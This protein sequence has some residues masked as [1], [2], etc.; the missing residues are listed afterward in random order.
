MTFSLATAK[1]LFKLDNLYKKIFRLTLRLIKKPYR[2]L[3]SSNIS[4]SNNS[5][6]KRSFLYIS[7]TPKGS[8]TLEAAIA[9]PLFFIGFISFIYIINII[10]L[11]SVLQIALEETM[12]DVSKEVYITSKF[13]AMASDNTD[14]SPDKTNSIIENLGARIITV[15]YIKDKFVT[16][17]IKKL[18]NS[19][20]VENGAD[21]LSFKFSFIDAGKSTLDII[22]DYKC[23]I[24][25]I[26][27]KFATFKLSNRYY[28][29]VY[30]GE[31]IDKEQNDTYFYI[32]YAGSGSVA[33]TNR[34]CQ[35]L[36]NYSKAIRI[37]ELLRFHPANECVLCVEHDTIESLYEKNSVVYVTSEEDI[38]HISLDC[39]SFTKDVFRIK[40]SSLEKEK[41]CTKCLEG[42]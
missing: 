34:Y 3:N 36:L 8:I 32:Y 39:Q 13:Y 20:F 42:K 30:S 21:G 27:S 10:Y 9:V 17:D 23:S 15:P 4:H 31:D 25:F 41:I 11:Q 14:I 6:S 28:T 2:Q 24:P 1:Y 12:R 18:L 19:S 40:V 38:Y 26:P 5:M 37:N 16:D 29:R 7:F 33:H 35:Y 22:I